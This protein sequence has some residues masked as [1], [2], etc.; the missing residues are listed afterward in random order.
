MDTRLHR[1]D[2]T[3]PAQTASWK[4]FQEFRNEGA[5]EHVIRLVGFGVDGKLTN[6]TGV[7]MTW[8]TD[9]PGGFSDRDIAV[10]ER[11]MPRLAL[12]VKSTVDHEIA[13]NLLDTYLGHQA[14]AAILGGSY[15]R[16]TFRIIPAA[17]LFADLRGFSGL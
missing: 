3:D 15:R 17:I 6:R 13:V 16:G 14:G 4:V 12:S 11:M 7:M 8:L 10:L 9:R 5:T 2:L 1:T